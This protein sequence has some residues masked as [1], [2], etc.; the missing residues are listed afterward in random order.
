[1]FVASFPLHDLLLLLLRKV[2]ISARAAGE[3]WRGLYNVPQL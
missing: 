3:D 2:S 1:M